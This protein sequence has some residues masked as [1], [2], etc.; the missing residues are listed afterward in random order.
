[1]SIEKQEFGVEE[2]SLQRIRDLVAAEPSSLRRRDELSAFKSLQSRFNINLAATRASWP[3]VRQIFT[4]RHPAAVG[5]SLKRFA[6]VRSSIIRTIKRYG[7]APQSLVA[8]FGRTEDWTDLIEKVSDRN[9]RSALNRLACHCSMAGVPPDRITPEVLIGFYE[10]L[11]NEEPIKNPRGIFRNAIGYWNE[12]A[13]KI[14]DWPQY[15]LSSP[16]KPVPTILPE[17]MFPQT[18]RDDVKRWRDR[19]LQVDLFDEKGPSRPSRPV[20]VDH[21]Q[22]MIYRF[23]SI[24]VQ[25]RLVEMDQL[26]SLAT[27][28]NLETLKS[29]LRVFLGKSDG[30]PTGYIGQY[31]SLL[32]GIARHH[33]RLPEDQCAGVAAL[34][35]KVRPKKRMGLTQR[36]RDRLAPFKTDERDAFKEFMK[37]PER[38]RARGMK[39]EN[40]YRRAKC[41]ERAL[42]IEILIFA[43]LRMKNLSTIHLDRNVREFDGKVILFFAGDE[44]KNGQPFESELPV[45]VS[46][47]FREF[48][49]RYRPLLKG[50]DDRFL[51]PGASGGAKHHSTLRSEFEKTVVR[52]TGLAVNP[53]LMRHLTTL[54]ALHKDPAL[55]PILAQRLGHSGLQTIRDFYVEN[56]SLQASR[57]M[58]ELLEGRPQDIM[59]SRRTAR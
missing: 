2:R 13:R 52:F 38:E 55:L 31:A 12:A 37:I 51:F 30:K 15:P 33:V 53:H 36:N 6:N 1:M 23:A 8:R 43:S 47:R 3:I 39:M 26:N 28:L 50:S 48:V 32:L 7:S 18:F 16:F 45:D 4:S 24:L 14:S 54:V 9:R 22:R 56:E 57:I 49:A 11:S 27:L 35:G 44:M 25:N 5:L 41:F 58:N 40:A 10:A 17:E 34:A 20:T 29:G 19:R 42:V 21:Q 59:S 46:I